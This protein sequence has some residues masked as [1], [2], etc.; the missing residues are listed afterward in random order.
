MKNILLATTNP[1][2]VSEARAS[3]KLYDIEVEQIELDIKEIQSHDPIEISIQK[4]RD[5]YKTVALPVVITDTSWNISA[6]NGFPGGYMKDVVEWFEPED[7]LNL[8]R[9]KA[10]RSVTFTETIVYMD[11]NQT[12][13]FSRE[14]KGVIAM[15]PRGKGN[16]IEQIAEFNGKTIAENHDVGKNSHDP[17][18]YIWYDFAKW[19]SELQ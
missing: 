13:V 9:E 16:T 17:K 1:R 3:C 12:K 6:L 11:A 14:F 15:E 7:F 5:A 2:K 19:Y 4:A 8:L 18:E 10:D